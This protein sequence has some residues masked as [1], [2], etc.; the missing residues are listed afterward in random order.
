MSNVAVM[1]P[2][3]ASRVNLRTDPGADAS[4]R[5]VGVTRMPLARFLGDSD[6]SLALHAPTVVVGSVVDVVVV[7]E[8]VVV[9]SVVDVAVVGSVV[10]VVVV[11]EVVVVGSV[12]DVVVVDTEKEDV[13]PLS[14]V[15]S[16]TGTCD[17]WSCQVLRF[18]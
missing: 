10:D 13:F 15:A 5:G 16:S 12:V 9:G 11:E 18:L 8:V 7:D 3:P 14:S 6:V 2:L 1:L 17:T 4:T